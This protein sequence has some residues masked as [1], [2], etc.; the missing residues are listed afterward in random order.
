MEA[1][2]F[3]SLQSWCF[4]NFLHTIM[5]SS[6]STCSTSYISVTFDNCTLKICSESILK[7]IMAKC[8]NWSHTSSFS[9]NTYYTSHLSFLCFNIITVLISAS[10]KEW[11]NELNQCTQGTENRAWHIINVTY[12]LTF[13]IVITTL[14]QAI[15][16]SAIT[17]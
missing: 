10:Y 12:K 11:G 3:Y 7:S 16:I 5:A 2:S 15:L 9:I 8:V 14:I 13:I 4:P 6:S 1:S 17:S